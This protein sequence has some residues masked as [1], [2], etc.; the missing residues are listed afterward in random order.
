MVDLATLILTRTVT[1]SLPPE[2]AYALVA[3]LP[4]MGEWSPVCKECVWDEGA[5]GA[6]VGAW[7][8]GKNV[9]GEREWET[10][11]EIVAASAGQ[12]LAWVVGGADEG[13]TRWGYTFR[14]ADGGTEIEESWRLVR[15]HERMAAMSPEDVDKLVARTTS[16]M[17]R[18]LA[19]IAE[20]AAGRPAAV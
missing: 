11:C 1:V 7:F 9:L 10:H 18:T 3:D 13:T 15:V 2:D 4:R 14:P 20:T 17:E 12:E 19:A 8:T 6:A 16:G 5:E